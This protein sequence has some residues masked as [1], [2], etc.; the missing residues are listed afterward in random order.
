[1]P[2]GIV[3]RSGPMRAVPIS[4]VLARELTPVEIE[5]LRSLGHLL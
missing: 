4:A 5:K 2:V 1:M 3:P